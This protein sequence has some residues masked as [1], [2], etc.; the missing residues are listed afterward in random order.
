MDMQ[1]DARN[2]N[3]KYQKKVHQK[4]KSTYVDVTTG[5]RVTQGSKKGE[6]GKRD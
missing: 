1:V 6:H 4:G 2:K 5:R 3:E